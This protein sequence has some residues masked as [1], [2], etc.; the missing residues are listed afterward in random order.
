[1]RA[2]LYARVSTADQDEGLQLPS[3]RRYCG[4]RGWEVAG[5]YSD[6]ASGRNGDRPGWKELKKAAR[7]HEFDAVCVTKIDRV[8]RSLQNFLKELEDFEAMGIRLVSMDFGDLN[9]GDPSGQLTIRLMACLAEWER[10]LISERT[11]AALKTKRE[12]GVTLGRPRRD[13]PVHTAALMRREGIP[14]E[15]IARRLGVPKSTLMGRK[16]E[17]EDEAGKLEEEEEEESGRGRM[18]RKSGRRPR[19]WSEVH[20]GRGSV[21]LRAGDKIARRGD[22]NSGTTCGR[23]PPLTD[24]A[25][26]RGM[27]GEDLKMRSQNGGVGKPPSL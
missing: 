1:M 25:R 5:E 3:L 6:E 17:I 9:P 24:S 7:R 10:E 26:G 14:W 19:P 22:D 16:G 8:M 23:T 11:K 4:E 18:N 13:I 2:A 27:G 21:M 15:K 20:I 12:R